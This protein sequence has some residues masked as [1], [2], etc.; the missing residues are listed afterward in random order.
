M[1]LDEALRLLDIATDVNEQYSKQER[2]RAT[3]RLEELLRL[4][5]PEE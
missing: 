3:M 2:I 5:L 4:L 1:R